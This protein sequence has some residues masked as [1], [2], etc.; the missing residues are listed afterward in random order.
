[1]TILKSKDQPTGTQLKMIQVSQNCSNIAFGGYNG[2]T[3]YITCQNKVYSLA[4]CVRGGE[5][6]NR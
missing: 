4:M 1:M 5:H 6:S 3:L 2:R